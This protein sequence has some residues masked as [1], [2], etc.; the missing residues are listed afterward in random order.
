MKSNYGLYQEQKNKLALTPQMY[1]SIEVLQLSLPE[2]IN[3][4]GIQFTEN[5]FLELDELGK[6][7][8]ETEETDKID[9]TDVTEENDTL[10]EEIVKNMDVS[11]FNNE[12]IKRDSDLEK[13]LN[14]EKSTDNNQTLYEH[15]LEQLQFI[16]CVQRINP[17]IY[18]ATKYII[19][20]LDSDGY[21]RMSLEEISDNLELTQ[22]ETEKALR[23][24]QQLEPWGIGA[25][26]LKECLILQLEYMTDCPCEIELMLDYLEELGVGHF[27]KIAK[28][29]NVP[30]DKIREYAKIISLLNPRPGSGFN[31]HSTVK[32]IIPDIIVRK[33]DNEYVIVINEKDI[34][35]L[36]VNSAYKKMLGYE[37]GSKIKKYI[38]EN[39]NS[40]LNLIKNIENRKNTIYSIMELIINKQTEFMEKGVSYLK[41][42]TMKQVA[43]EL[44]IHESTVSRAISNKYVQTPIGTFGIKSFFAGS[45]KQSETVTSE[46]IKSEIK[47]IIC[48][49]NPQKPLSDND[50]T[51]ELQERGITVSRRTIAKYRDEMG[52]LSTVLRKKKQR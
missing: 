39:Y 42:L 11:N 51:T 26:T 4:I 10:W 30:V 21:L 48:A 50:I 13:Y 49:E 25:R 38:T 8:E 16:N 22:V 33:I 45:I 41:P 34:P 46:K 47:R 15:L 18:L 7:N 3:Y 24:V 6:E 9:K 23:L 19:E 20:N 14:F 2:L 32:Y 35:R 37:E 43:Q 12:P 52:I 28:A 1:Q 27:N 31:D 40:A 5:P 29:I 17:K 36:F 44:G